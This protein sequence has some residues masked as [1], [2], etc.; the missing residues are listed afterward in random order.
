MPT[1][2][3]RYDDR[4]RVAL[5][6]RL[7]HASELGAHARRRVDDPEWERQ[8]Q[9]SYPAQMVLA[10]LATLPEVA[11]NLRRAGI[12]PGMRVL[13]AGCGPG[14]L[15]RL[16]ADL[17]AA[18]VVGLDASPE[19]LD[20]ATRLE[21]VPDPAVCRFVQADLAA[22]LP[23]DLGTFDA[24]VYGDVVRAD[25]LPGLLGLLRL[26]SRLIVKLTDLL[27][28]QSIAWDPALDLRLRLALVEGMRAAGP[29]WAPLEGPGEAG[30]LRSLGW[31][32]LE[33]WS[34]AAE[35]FAPA[36]AVWVEHTLQSFA[37]FRSA[38]IRLVARPD[39]WELACRLHDRGSGSF[40]FDRPDGHF[41]RMLTFASGVPTR[42]GSR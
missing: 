11:A 1:W 5:A 36:P 40:L 14:V 35:R 29:P 30:R 8:R 4:L 31:E 13:D 19:M 15:T 27:P 33:V 42:A 3:P 37:L 22:P 18:E 23:Q 26:G 24:V 34:V 12:S 6:D 28:G 41:V 32:E 38:F 25:L 17:G 16:L 20:L 39:D 10:A 7:L 2:T 9:A 21:P